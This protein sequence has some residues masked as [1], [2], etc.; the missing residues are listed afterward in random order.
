MGIW[1]GVASVEF[2]WPRP[3]RCG[4]PCGIM[5]HACRSTRLQ[6]HDGAHEER[7]RSSLG[8]EDSHENGPALIHTY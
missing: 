7:P 3:S 1:Y 4:R 8:H 6:Q 5:D 2:T